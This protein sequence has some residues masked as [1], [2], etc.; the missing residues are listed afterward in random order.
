MA[1]HRTN[2]KTLNLSTQ[3]ENGQWPNR[4]FA[5]KK[6]T[7]RKRCSSLMAYIQN[8]LIIEI[9]VLFINLQERGH[10]FGVLS[11]GNYERDMQTSTIIG[12]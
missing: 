6:K 9:I 5:K 11:N 2:K 1:R 7:I 12:N 4:K 3:I 10:Y 8:I